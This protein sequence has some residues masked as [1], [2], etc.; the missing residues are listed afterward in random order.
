VDTEDNSRKPFSE[1]TTLV[2]ILIVVFGTLLAVGA[3]GL[4]VWAVGI[5]WKAA[6]GVWS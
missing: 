3:L 4:A 6:I 2:K 1:Q 5:I